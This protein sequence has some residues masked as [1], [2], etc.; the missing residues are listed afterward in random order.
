MAHPHQSL[1]PN[2]HQPSQPFILVSLNHTLKLTSTN[3]I[4]WKTQIEA[5]LIG[6]DLHKYVDGSFPTP[7]KLITFEGLEADNPAYN[8]WV[9][10]DKLL[11]GAL[12]GTLSDPLVPLISRCTTSLEAWN[13]LARTFANPSKGH[14]K[15]IKERFRKITKGS[16]SITDYMYDIKNCANQLASLGKPYEEDVLIE[17]ILEQL[18]DSDYDSIVQAMQTRETT[19]SFD[20]L[21]E[22]L[23]NRE[24]SIAHK[25]APLMYPATA[26]YA[27]KPGYKGRQHSQPPSSKPLLPTP[28]SQDSSKP[29]S[30]PYLGKCQ[31]CRQAGHYVSQCPI[32]RQQFP[33]ATPPS[34]ATVVASSS[35]HRSPP[36]GYHTL[37][38][39][40]AYTAS[41]SM[42]H[43]T[44][45]LLDS[46]A[47]HHV[48][49]DL[50][51]LSLHA[52]YGGSDELIIG[53]GSGLPI[54]NTGYSSF[55]LNS[56]SLHLNNV[57]HV[58][59]ASRNII[60]LSKLCQD[61]NISIVFSS[62][63]FTVKEAQLGTLLFQGS[64]NGGIYELL[65]PSS[66]TLHS[67]F[68]PTSIDWHHKLGHPSISVLK[69]CSTLFN[70]SVPSTLHCNACACHKSHK[71]PFFSS[72]VTS[73]V[74]LDVIY[75][76]VWTSP[77]H[78]FDG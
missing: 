11:Y 43:T 76:D 16:R 73:N 15:Q 68:V 60:S 26:N 61:N 25:A 35:Q 28:V 49:N 64:N 19:I 22:K 53:D 17:K 24:L 66:P 21:H 52:P 44:G 41:T 31:W 51:N 12:A 27:T 1:I 2:A 37:H 78:S 33:H 70:L 38:Q 46:G 30:K 18:N 77:I 9:R 75:S 7:S 5:T 32:F 8:T 29:Q 71:L 55:I 36:S 42:P 34:Q 62:T 48:T 45:W 69:Q 23:L 39:P 54:A 6:Y 67:A 14:V 40:T 47:S 10:Q 4:S 57:L 63:S 72:T 56:T 20:E 13:T 74:P 59:S 65:P 3:Y 58:P 50:D